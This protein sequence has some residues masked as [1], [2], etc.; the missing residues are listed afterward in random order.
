MMRIGSCY[1]FGKQ[2]AILSKELMPMYE[3][4]HYHSLIR[5]VTHRIMAIIDCYFCLLPATCCLYMFFLDNV[6]DRRNNELDELD[7]EF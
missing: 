1:R 6:I 3:K 7:F 5:V 2:V 4:R